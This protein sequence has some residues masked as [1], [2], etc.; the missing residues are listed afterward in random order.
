MKNFQRQAGKAFLVTLAALATSV[1]LAT[2]SVA[3]DDDD[4]DDGAAGFSS[5]TIEGNWGFSGSGTILPPALP[6]PTV[7]VVVG[8]FSFDGSGGCTIT[9]QINIGGQ[10]IP[11]SLGFR[12]SQSCSY[13]VNRDGTGTI[14]V[15][16]P[17]DPAPTPLSF[18]IVDEAEELYFI[19]A[20]LGVANGVATRQGDADD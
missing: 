16:F 3:D 9:D 11:S 18:V 14:E 5:E 4:D 8:I 12:S 10:A 13:L 19:R 1:M 6:A 7:A 20:D 2:W 17:G 15:I